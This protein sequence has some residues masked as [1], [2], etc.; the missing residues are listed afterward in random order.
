[1]YIKN[2]NNISEV[3]IGV[4]QLLTASALSN[5][6]MRYLISLSVSK[7]LKKIQLPL[8]NPRH[9]G[10]Q[11]YRVFSDVKFTKLLRF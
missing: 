2:Q 5:L 10:S 6:L 4:Q 3:C 9:R 11:S 1:M 8:V 7:S